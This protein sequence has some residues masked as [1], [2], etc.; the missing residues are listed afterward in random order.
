M[1]VP[2]SPSTC[3]NANTC[4][5]SVLKSDEDGVNGVICVL[6]TEVIPFASRD[7]VFLIG[8]TCMKVALDEKLKFFNL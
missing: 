8:F 3:L 2:L 7:Q 4:I 1:T 6:Y 5:S